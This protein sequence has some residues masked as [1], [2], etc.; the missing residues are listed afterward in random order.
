MEGMDGGRKEAEG[1]RRRAL[2]RTESAQALLHWALKAKCGSN[3]VLLP[4][5]PIVQGRQESQGSVIS[6][7]QLQCGGVCVLA[8]QG[9]TLHTV[10]VAEFEPYTHKSYA[11]VYHTGPTR[12][13]ML[14]RDDLVKSK[15]SL[16]Y[17]VYTH[18]W[19]SRPASRYLEGP[20]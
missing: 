20:R 12:G 1:R 13:V 16:A 5:S 14:Q 8:S 19:N 7:E 6:S 9:C 18:T 4:R 11:R 3:L 10:P 17:C 15:L 2:C